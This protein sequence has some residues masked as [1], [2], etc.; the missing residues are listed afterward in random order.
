[1]RGLKDTGA[2]FPGKGPQVRIDRLLRCDRKSIG[3]VVERDGSLTVRAPKRAGMGAIDEAV[4]VKAE[5]IL[6]KQEQSRGR[7]LM[8][9]RHGYGEGER[10]E[11]LG[12]LYPLALSSGAKGVALVGGGLVAP[13]GAADKIRDKVCVWYKLEARRVME[14]RLSLYCA[15]MGVSCRAFRLSG[16]R[17][18]WG[19]CSASGG[20]SLNWRLVAA[21]VNVI[22]YVVV[23]ELSHLFYLDH[24]AAFWKTVEQALPDYRRLRAWLKEHQALLECF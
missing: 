18:R 10:F 8:H 17:T 24:S 21:P 9:P 12:A 7:L 22:D 6:H 20:I 2:G 16:A 4:R 19:S 1:M 11:Y 5:W 15:R 14:E 23:H 13:A 3:L